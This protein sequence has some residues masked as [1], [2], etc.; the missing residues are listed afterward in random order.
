MTKGNIIKLPEKTV[1][2]DE[3]YQHYKGDYYKVLTMALHS[4]DENYLVIYEAQYPNP[5]YKYFA[6]PLSKWFDIVNFQDKHAQR[7]T[8]IPTTDHFLSSYGEKIVSY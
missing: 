1:C 7:F 5:D 3:I 6:L 8:R 2:P 4:D